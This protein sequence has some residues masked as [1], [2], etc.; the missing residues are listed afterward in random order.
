M[1]IH[2]KG[3]QWLLEKY[4]TPLSLRFLVSVSFQGFFGCTK[5]LSIQ[6]IEMLKHR[7]GRLNSEEEKWGK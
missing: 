6:R 1:Y 3:T 2:L 4:I 7:D 5:Y